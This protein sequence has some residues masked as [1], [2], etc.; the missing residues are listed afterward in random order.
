M[1]SLDDGKEL[2]EL[3]RDSIKSCFSK[4]EA[5]VSEE[6]KEKYREKQGVFVTLKKHGDLRGCIGFPEPVHELW[7]GL[8]EA[9]KAAAFDDPRFSPL[10]EKE[11]EEI[12][13]EVSVLTKPELI[14]ARSPEEYV[15]KIKIGKD[16]LIIRAGLF[17]G[18]LLPIVAVEYDWTPEQFL[19]RVCMKAGMTMD[20][21]KTSG[22]QIYK[23]QTQVF[24]E[25]D[26]KVIE[27]M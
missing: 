16:G 26:G 7:L 14:K 8:I 18:L 4:E 11:L 3:A 27:K 13:I 17:S 1:F 25:E 22:K 5:E 2:V 24:A 15:K 19:R 23:F 9:A 6:I 10:K 20:A 21:W 12:E